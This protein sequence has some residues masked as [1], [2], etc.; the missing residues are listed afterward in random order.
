MTRDVCLTILLAAALCGCATGPIRA[1]V[2]DAQTRQP[3]PGAVVLGVWTK[4][5]S[6]LPYHHDFVGVRETDTD[7]DGRFELERLPSSGLRGE[8]G[9]QSIT[10]Y[11]FGYIGWNNLEVFPTSKLRE[12]QNIP[13]EILLERFPPA[14][15]HQQ[16]MFFISNSMLGGMYGLDLIPR[17]EGAIEQERKLR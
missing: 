16:H 6:G 2:L 9:G 3:I 15:S 7:A 11:K 12:D 8:G 14:E 4:V 1:R 13:S 17:F 10:V 5:V